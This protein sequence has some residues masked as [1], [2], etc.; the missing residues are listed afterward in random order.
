MAPKVIGKGP[1]GYVSAFPARSLKSVPGFRE[2]I[3]E[4]DHNDPKN[5]VVERIMGTR[6]H[7]GSRQFLIRYEDYPT[8]VFR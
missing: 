5:Y 2:D 7:E 4:V 3:T 6:L 8:Y 1:N